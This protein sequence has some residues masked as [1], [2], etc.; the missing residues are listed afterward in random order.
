VD[1]RPATCR[2]ALIVGWPFFPEARSITENATDT[3]PVLDLAQSPPAPFGGAPL[4]SKLIAAVA[5]F[6][7]FQGELFAGKRLLPEF[8]GAAYV[9]C[10]VILFFQLVLIIG[11]YSSRAL[12][13][14][15]SKT[16]T[17]IL[18]LLGLSG[19]VSLTPHLPQAAWLPAELQPFAALQPFAG[20]SVA[21]FTT[22]PLLHRRQVDRT[23]YRIYAWS[24]A[25]AFLGLLT[26]PFVVEPL[27]PLWVQ[28]VVWAVGGLFIV[29]VGLAGPS[30]A[31]DPT[32]DA[33]TRGATRWQWW[34]LPAVSSALLLA[35]TNRLSYEASAGPLTWALPLAVFLF[36]YVL[37]FGVRRGVPIGVTAVIGLAVLAVSFVELKYSV[38]MLLMILTAGGAGMLACNAWLAA[39]RNENSHGFYRA[40]AIG[41]AVGSAIVVLVVP[42]VTQWPI[43]F[44]ILAI[45]ALAVAGLWRARNLM[46]PVVAI[47]AL[48]A[49]GCAVYDTMDLDS[50]QH[51]LIRARTLY[52]CLSITASP[53]G[54]WRELYNNYTLHGG[55]DREVDGGY[56]TYYST[57]SG[58][59]KLIAARQRESPSIKVGA[60]GL[61]TGTLNWHMR[62][63]D[64]MTFYEIDPKVEELSTKYFTYLERDNTW[65]VL[66][67]ARRSLER[68]E[69]Q[70]FDVLVLDAFS[71]DAI[72]THLLTKEAGAIYRRHLKPDGAIAINITNRYAD[73]EPVAKG[74]ACDLGMSVTLTSEGWATWATLT[75]GGPAP[76]GKII[77]WTDQRNSILSVLTY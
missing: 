71:G 14:T 36:T 20:L 38:Y 26:Y 35:T 69:S 28:N 15:D 10:T 31:P 27:T 43:E 21:L 58:V 30:V 45:G 22:T 24:N 52:G 39:T 23:D 8:G 25:G 16:R 67:D 40:T 53:D 6:L 51:V 4:R 59:A 3:A 66:G 72:P 76:D 56:L 74:L 75:P 9:W 63:D 49:I 73:L 55:E 37:A 19:L 18:A 65:V 34:V 2:I 5:G 61:G 77:E 44:P 62:P 68:Q 17:W 50:D 12:A 11:Y 13:A 1:S 57:T 41:G 29:T 60:V 32:T 46:K 42:R 64:S 70:Q 47:A 54:R 48:A 7:M 33:P